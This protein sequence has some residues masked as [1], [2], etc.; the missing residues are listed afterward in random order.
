MNQERYYP[1]ILHTHS[2]EYYPHSIKNLAIKIN[3]TIFMRLSKKVVKKYLHKWVILLILQ[4]K[5]I[6]AS[7]KCLIYLIIAI[8]ISIFGYN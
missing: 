6:F 8:N 2:N 5:D 1:K 7:S 4:I 3:F